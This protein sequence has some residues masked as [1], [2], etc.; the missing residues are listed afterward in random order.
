[1]RARGSQSRSLLPGCLVIALLFIWLEALA[2]RVPAGLDIGVDDHPP[3]HEL[4][5]PLP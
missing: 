5:T 3:G 4:P 1:M 2:E